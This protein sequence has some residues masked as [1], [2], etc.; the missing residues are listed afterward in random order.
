MSVSSLPEWKQLLLEKKRREEEERG[1]REK[2]EEEKFANMPAWKRGIIQRRKAKQEVLF[3]REK[4]REFSVLQV[5][6]Q[7]PSDGLSDTD[8]SVAVNQGNEQSLSPDPG[9]WLGAE[10]KPASEVSV[11]TIVPVHENPFIRTQSVWRKGK[12]GDVGHH[13]VDAKE[14]DKD[15]LT[16]KSHD[17]ERGRGMNIE[18]KIE[19]FRDLSEGRDKERSRDRSQG[20]ETTREVW[21]KD[22]CSWKDV[23]KDKE[24]LK[25]EHETDRP[26]SFSSLVPCLRTIRA[27]NIII[28]EQEQRGND[29]RRA[30]WTDVEVDRSEEELQGKRG[31]KMDLREILA[32]GASVT[33]IRASDV[34]IIKPTAS[35]EE[36]TSLGGGGKGSGRED[37]D[38]CTT[39]GKRELRTDMSWLKENSKDT[40]RLCSQ[41]TMIKDNRRDSLD[42]N[43][44]HEKGG[45]V[46]QLLTKFG[47][48]RKPPSRSKSSD[49][50]L[51]P[52]RR[53]HFGENN[54]EQT[55]ECM[56]D[57]RNMPLR[58]V[59]KRSFSFSDRV[60]CDK[61]NGLD[62]DV[63]FERK[64]CERVYSDKSVAG[65]GK[66]TPIKGKI[67]CTRL[68]DKDKFGKDAESNEDQR[69]AIPRRGEIR[70]GFQNRTEVKK[71]D[72]VERRATGMPNDEDREG[73]TMAS[74]K[75]TEGISFARRIPI[76]QD[77][78]TRTAE[79]TVKRVTEKSE[80][81]AGN[82]CDSG[83]QNCDK[84]LLDA[85]ENPDASAYRS[86]AETCFRLESDHREYSGLLSTVVQKG[87]EHS[88]L[89]YQTEDLINKIEKVGDTTDYTSERTR[90]IQI[91]NENSTPR[92]PKRIP[93]IGNP[94]CALEI[95]IPRTVF[96]V[97]EELDR[98]KNS[99]QSQES[100]D[101]EGGCG[102]E[103]RDSWR[104]GK[105]LS[106]I[107]SLREKIRQREQER[108][109]QRTTHG[110]DGGEGARVSDASLITADDTCAETRTEKPAAHLQKTMVGAESCEED[111]EAQTSVTAFDITQEVGLLKNSPQL[112]VSVQHSHTV[113]GEEVSRDLAHATSEDTGE[114]HQISQDEPNPVKHVEEQLTHHR[115]QEEEEGKEV[116]E[117]EVEAYTLSFDPVQPLSPSP[118]HPNS[119]A[120][121]SR[122]YNLET[123]GSRSG[124]CLRD[125]NV[126]VTSVHLLKVKPLISE[127]AQHRDGNMFSGEDTCGLQKFQLQ[128][129]EVT[130]SNTPY[131]EK[132][133]KGPQSKGMKK[134][135]LKDYAKIE[136]TGQETLDMNSIVRPRCFFP[137]TSQ[138]KQPS[139]I[140]TSHLRSQSPDRS[141]K[142]SDCAPTPVSSPCSP[143]PAA[144]PTAS[145]TLFSIRSAS[146]GHVKR[147]ATV[148]ITPKK[149]TVAGRTADLMAPSITAACTNANTLQ[150]HQT[151]TLTVA[152]PMKKKYPTAEEIE[153]IGG[154][155]N[156]EKSCLVRSKGTQKLGK[157]CFDED[158][159]EQ[160]CE[161]PSETSMWA[162]A[163]SEIPQGEETQEAEADGGAIVSKSSRNLT[164]A[165]GHRLRVDESC[166]R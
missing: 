44:F 20:R 107:E 2:E 101:L 161:Y 104:V 41:A 116:S 3:D 15:K 21:E 148:T 27:D 90:G 127:N 153:V 76:R 19:R 24:F 84:T 63:C 103:R 23:A 71:L 50:F 4:E 150:K 159:L 92:S 81:R 46:S 59:P 131:K 48:H 43:V 33:E 126:D 165:I 70:I 118:P 122:I 40:D 113:D 129:Q 157:V 18:L 115:N 52:G 138:L 75:S 114:S 29:E 163:T 133:T 38:A 141:L 137:P 13:E 35:M 99:S 110:V 32:G 134:H 74:V 139:P 73:F 135:Q 166:P 6:A 146:G 49:N 94:P 105:P 154:Y 9:Q 58:G 132:E 72:P 106:R 102:V 37:G 124:L 123:V 1:R 164:T 121:M 128:E 130:I 117:K 31:M 145:P 143:S 57:G 155:Q 16:P 96:Y 7:P 60:L 79:K 5:D 78:K 160:V 26:S 69:D 64:T 108:L 80:L 28:I 100:K 142:P 109:R 86:T 158:Q 10:P 125:R 147:G 152:E 111:A 87:A 12:E 30:K 42:E 156:L 66:D 83:R 17:G 54:N 67:V 85:F 36:R 51:R 8:S 55:V 136:G 140:N 112:P 89:S 97:A 56:S 39:E 88:G 77:V 47:E 149:S 65:L 95:Q 93:P 53:K 45:R 68:L 144:S 119:L 82:D 34:L 11:E 61:E 22:K 98:K 120:A 62:P 14:R 25:E 91:P 151:P 162:S